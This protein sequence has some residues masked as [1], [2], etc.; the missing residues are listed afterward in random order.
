[1]KFIKG[2]LCASVAVLALSFSGCKKDSQSESNGS[3]NSKSSEPSSSES[4]ASIGKFSPKVSE[5][6]VIALGLNLDLHKMATIGETF[7]DQGIATLTSA[8]ASLRYAIAMDSPVQSFSLPQP[9]N[10]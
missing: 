3:N 7:F 1:M 8:N 2:F 5:N 9:T 10:T 6:A 4:S